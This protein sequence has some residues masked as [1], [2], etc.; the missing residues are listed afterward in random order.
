MDTLPQWILDIQHYEK[1]LDCGCEPYD[2][3]GAPHYPNCVIQYL[4]PGIQKLI[5][6]LLL[7]K[8]RNR[9]LAAERDL[10]RLEVRTY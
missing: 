8:A 3:S 1:A 4:K 5:H 2:D 7:E 6:E 9:V 10:A